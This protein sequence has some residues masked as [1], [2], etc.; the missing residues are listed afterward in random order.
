MLDRFETPGASWGAWEAALECAPG[1][2][3]TSASLHLQVLDRPEFTKS[4]LEKLIWICAF[5]LVGARHGGCTV[6]EVESQVGRGAGPGAGGRGHSWVLFNKD[7]G[8]VLASPCSL[9]HGRRA[10]KR[11]NAAAL[12]LLHPAA[13]F[14]TRQRSAR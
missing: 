2:R 8:C 5:M 12:P 1:L 13:P 7:H 9:R 4:M 3:R 6:G 10:C 14:S 11:T